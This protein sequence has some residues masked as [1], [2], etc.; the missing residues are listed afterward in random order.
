MD[1]FKLNENEEVELTP[2][3]FNFEK[4]YRIWR[5]DKSDDKGRA[6]GELSYVY[7]M[8]SIDSPYMREDDEEERHR[9][10]VAAIGLPDD[11]QPDRWLVEA[12]KLFI[13]V[14]ET[15]TISYLKVSQRVLNSM[16]DEMSKINFKSH[17]NAQ[18]AAKLKVK[19]EQVRKDIEEAVKADEMITKLREKVINE[20]K[21]KKAKQDRT[22]GKVKESSYVSPEKIRKIRNEGAAEHKG[23]D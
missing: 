6:R 14:Q 7:L 1:I 2:W 17:R 12:I 4:I 23:S 8:N 19:P 9:D 20:K 18:N 10:V 13:D 22:R 16:R 15:P 5:R 11:W 21:Q 3:V